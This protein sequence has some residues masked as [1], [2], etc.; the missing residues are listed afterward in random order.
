MILNE[1]FKTGVGRTSKEPYAMLT[2][3]CVDKSEPKAARC[4][5]VL[6]LTLAKED[7]AYKDQLEDEIIEIDLLELRGEFRGCVQGSARIV[8][9]AESQA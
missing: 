8:R 2:V 3:R 9:E 4:K 6:E 1:I 7:N 5:S